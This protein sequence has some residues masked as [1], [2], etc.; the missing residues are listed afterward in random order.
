M[1]LYIRKYDTYRH[2]MSYFIMK[3]ESYINVEWRLLVI[4]GGV[5]PEWRHMPVISALGRLRQEDHK[6]KASL[7]YMVRS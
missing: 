5:N 3:C 1:H 2:Y 7:G 6:F 4:D